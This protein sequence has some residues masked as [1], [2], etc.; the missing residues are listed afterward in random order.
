MARG[1]LTAGSIVHENLSLDVL[2]FNV[3]FRVLSSCFF[4]RLDKDPRTNSSI[5]LL[6]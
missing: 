3:A 6:L 4:K 1:G 2:V 5:G